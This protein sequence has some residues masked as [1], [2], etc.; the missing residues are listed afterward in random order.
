[1]VIST[2]QIQRQWST[3]D[4]LNLKAGQVLTS[5]GHWLRN[6]KYWDKK[7]VKLDA[8]NYT[9][10]KQDQTAYNLYQSGKIDATA[11]GG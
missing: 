8:I 4:H 3:M 11:L 1:M 7:K 9:V 6:D 2:E 5:S 10:N